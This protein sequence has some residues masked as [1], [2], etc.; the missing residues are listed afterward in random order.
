M[1]SV[2]LDGLD[3]SLTN[4]EINR[5]APLG[6]IHYEEGKKKNLGRNAENQSRQSN[7][8]RTNCAEVSRP[9]E[10]C[11]KETFCSVRQGA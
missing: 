7:T 4:F 5:G 6:N 2:G 11:A 8:S 10:V 9:K 3:K 1:S